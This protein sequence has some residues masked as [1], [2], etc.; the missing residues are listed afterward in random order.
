MNK[1]NNISSG[2]VLITSN[3]NFMI[4]GIECCGQNTE[5]FFGWCAM[6]VDDEYEYPLEI[7]YIISEDNLDLLI[8]QIKTDQQIIEIVKSKVIL[9]EKESDIY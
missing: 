4:V 6:Y 1:I 7:Q 5:E 3:G 8:E 9:A 2:D